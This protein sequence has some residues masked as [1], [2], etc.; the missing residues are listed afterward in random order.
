MVVQTNVL[1]LNAH[2]HLK[3]TGVQKMRSAHRL[4]SGYFINSA[5]DDAAGLSISENMRAQI[6]GLDQAFRNSQD[7]IALIQTADGGLTEINNLLQRIRE[8]VV[9]A[10]NN[11]NNMSQRQ[12]IQTEITQLHDEIDSITYRVQY[13][14][15]RLLDGSL[16]SQTFGIPGGVGQ[17]GV[18]IVLTP[19]LVEWGAI[20]IVNHPVQIFNYATLPEQASVTAVLNPF[21]DVDGCAT[22]LAGMT[23]GFSIVGFGM[24]SAMS[25]TGIPAPGEQT[26]AEFLDGR[27][28]SFGSNVPGAGGALQMTASVNAATREISFTAPIRT[29]NQSVTADGI[30]FT[31]VVPNGGGAYAHVIQLTGVTGANLLQLD[32]STHQTN[33][34][35]QLWATTT[36][37]DNTFAFHILDTYSTADIDELIRNFFRIQIP[38]ILPQINTSARDI[39]FRRAGQN[40]IPGLVEPFL[41]AHAIVVDVWDGMT[42]AELT[43]GIV[44]ALDSFASTTV[45][46]VNLSGGVLNIDIDVAVQSPPHPTNPRTIISF[47]QPRSFIYNPGDP[48]QP[49]IYHDVTQNLGMLPVSVTEVSQ[50]TTEFPHLKHLHMPSSLPPSRTGSFT[51]EIDGRTETFYLI[52]TSVVPWAYRANS[53]VYIPGHMPDPIP[54]NQLGS[55]LHRNVIDVAGR[56]DALVLSDIRS[57]MQQGVLN[58]PASQNVNVNW[59]SAASRFEIQGPI[60][61]YL[62]DINISHSPLEIR[63]TIVTQP[64]RPPTEGAYVIN[65]FFPPPA[66]SFMDAGNQYFQREFYVNAQMATDGAGNFNAAGQGGTGFTFYNQLFE[67]VLDGAAP[68][69]TA[70]ATTHIHINSS[71][72]AA[73]VANAA[74]A[75]MRTRFGAI[76]AG[77]G[78]AQNRDRFQAMSR[79]AFV[80]AGPGGM[81]RIGFVGDARAAMTNDVSPVFPASTGF[82]NGSFVANQLFA[83]S[84]RF[85]GGVDAGQPYTVIDF[86]GMA[87][88]DDLIGRGFRIDCASCANEFFNVIFVYDSSEFNQAMPPGFYHPEHGHVYIRNMLVEL[89]HAGSSAESVAAQVGTQLTAQMDHF[90]RVR[91]DGS[92]LY[93]YDIRRGDLP[94][95]NDDGYMRGAVRPGV[96]AN[97]TMTR[98]YIYEYIPGTTVE[99][100]A[101]WLQTGANARQGMFVTIERMD[102]VGLNLR[103]AT[104]EIIIDVR[105]ESGADI[106]PQI[107][108][109]DSAMNIVNNR[110]A[111]LGAKQNRLEHT[112]RHLSISSQNLRDAESRIRNA[113]MAREM[114]ALAKT[115]VL[116][117]SGLLM[118]AQANQLPLNM[119]QLLI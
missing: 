116:Q 43:A 68:L 111:I 36:S 57:V 66:N 41:P 20:P 107:G 23:F 15:I 86:A 51:V 110:R 78:N 84:V 49:L 97:F 59:N 87:N 90:K 34:S 95:A 13:N 75:A 39:V 26:V 104:G 30:T 56:S 115:T 82:I 73:E 64:F 63:Y 42:G 24:G 31:H 27:T 54:I 32:G 8:L 45:T 37:I 106:S 88:M 58:F 77:Q 4:S 101:L 85:T 38:E 16:G 61:E 108:I 118:L 80:E 112:V 33:Q 105:Q 50:P 65:T 5:A 81:F 46:N 98:E 114:R 12:M 6:R 93:I 83:E 28:F 72:S 10:A 89:S 91:V 18:N 109:A 99:G 60:N 71:M 70:A 19:N 102:T 9:Q 62:P 76:Y 94:G 74:Q 40:T 55:V 67:F 69:N 35:E 52:D 119:L 100:R 117:Q 96:L 21:L 53:T 44:A 29:L 2:R 79:T 11:T 3:N 25:I 113:D 7:G 1:S 92:R 22:Q 14:T 47:L 48:G 103:Q 17:V